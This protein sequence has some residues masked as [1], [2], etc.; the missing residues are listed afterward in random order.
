MARARNACHI[1]HQAIAYILCVVC[2]WRC[3][4]TSA[5]SLYSL[6][7]KPPASLLCCTVSGEVR[8]SKNPQGSICSGPNLMLT[9]RMGGCC[10]GGEAGGVPKELL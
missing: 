8:V 6:M 7:R 10:L 5:Y 1:L 9:S 2:H 4:S 3:P